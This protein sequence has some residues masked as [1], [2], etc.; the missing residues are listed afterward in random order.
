MATNSFLDLNPPRASGH[1]NKI[2]STKP[3]VLNIANSP[4]T[5][6]GFVSSRRMAIAR[7]IV[8]VI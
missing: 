3:L 5:L 7:G 1:T 8:N 2:K 4:N 6:L